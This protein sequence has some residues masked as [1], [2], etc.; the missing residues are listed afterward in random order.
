MVCKFCVATLYQ[1]FA[2][3]ARTSFPHFPPTRATGTS[4]LP[5]WLTPRT[6]DRVFFRASATSLYV[7]VLSL[8]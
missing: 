3:V 8:K 4:H 5:V 7:T 6:Y 2:R 1:R